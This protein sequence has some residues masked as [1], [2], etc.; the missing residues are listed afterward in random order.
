MTDKVKLPGG[1]TV[2]SSC[3]PEAPAPM[4]RCCARL[5]PSI[6]VSANAAQSVFL[7]RKRPTYFFMMSSSGTPSSSFGRECRATLMSWLLSN[8]LDRALGRGAAQR[9][10][11]HNADQHLTIGA[12][13]VNIVGRIDR[14]GR[15]R[16]GARDRHLADRAAVE[17]AFDGGEP[18][19]PV[20][21]ADGA[22][23]G[24]DRSAGAILVVEQRGA[25]QREVA[26]AAGEFGKAKTAARRPGR[27]TNFGDDLV[28]R[29]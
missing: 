9:T 10:L 7:S 23:M 19:R 13:G 22:G 25:S 18:H 8:A 16:F 27:Q 15:R 4:K 2:G 28:G 6:L 1:I 26:A 14:G 5:K 21:D 20:G 3:L 12:A 17:N 24:V 29:E 11:N